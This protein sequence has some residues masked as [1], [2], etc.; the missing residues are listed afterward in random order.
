MDFLIHERY[1]PQ[2]Q[3][4]GNIQVMFLHYRHRE[5]NSSQNWH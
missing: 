3:Q 2:M 5:R 4:N 1:K